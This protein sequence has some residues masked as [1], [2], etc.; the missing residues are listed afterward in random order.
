M[1]ADVTLRQEVEKFAHI[2]FAKQS[3]ATFSF[4]SVNVT[5]TEVEVRQRYGSL[6]PCM[7]GSD[8]TRAKL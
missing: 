2:I 3:S 1:A 5:L 4:G 8:V 6:K 7:H